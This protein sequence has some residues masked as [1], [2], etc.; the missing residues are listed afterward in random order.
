MYLISPQ[1]LGIR[2]RGT[3]KEFF[4]GKTPCPLNPLAAVE[5]NRKEVYNGN[6]KIS[7]GYDFESDYRCGVGNSR[8]CRCKCDESVTKK[9]E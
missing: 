4:P 3:A 9:I 5:K 6:E 2:R 8:R 1:T 7:M